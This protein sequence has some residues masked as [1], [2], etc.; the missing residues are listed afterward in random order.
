MSTHTNRQPTVLIIDNDEDLLTAL[1]TRIEHMGYRCVTA[2]TG[3]Q[4][5]S[6]FHDD[7]IDLVITDMNMPVLDGASVIKQIR[8]NCQTP[9][10][11]VTGFKKDLCRN[12]AGLPDIQII[13]K[14]FNSQDLMDAIES[15]LFLSRS[16]AA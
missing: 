13:E 15:E 10:I 1:S 7:T 16:K 11:I 5:L 9:I 12:L 14:P 8:Q 4:G 2:R 6:E 3:A